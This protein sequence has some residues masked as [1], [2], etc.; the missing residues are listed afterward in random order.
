MEIV[1]REIVFNLGNSVRAEGCVIKT[2]SW[3]MALNNPKVHIPPAVA[4]WYITLL[5]VEIFTPAKSY[6]YLSHQDAG[7]SQC[8]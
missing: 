7:D 2:E 5:H 1:L 8:H 3:Q 6:G 4:T